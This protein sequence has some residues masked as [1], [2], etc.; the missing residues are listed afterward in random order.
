MT[1]TLS[2]T[3]KIKRMGGENTP[4][5]A[6]S[7]R[8]LQSTPEFS[9]ITPVLNISDSDFELPAFKPQ[10]SGLS[11]AANMEPYDKAP[12]MVTETL[13]RRRAIISEQDQAYQESLKADQKKETV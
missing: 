2:I 10:L 13:E 5:R 12:T 7:I 11:P 8:D 4:E 1:K 9:V 6:V 3:E